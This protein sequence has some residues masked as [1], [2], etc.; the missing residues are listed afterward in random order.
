MIRNVLQTIGGQITTYPIVALL[1]F[2]SFFT[3]MLLW[4]ATMSRRHIDHMSHLPLEREPTAP[5]ET[6]HE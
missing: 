4:V 6:N 5:G 3:G 1:I 2:V